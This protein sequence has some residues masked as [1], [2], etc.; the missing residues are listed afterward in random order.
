MTLKMDKADLDSPCGE[1]S[2]GGFKSV[3]CSPS[4]SLVN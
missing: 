1:L 3:V 2:N 4:G